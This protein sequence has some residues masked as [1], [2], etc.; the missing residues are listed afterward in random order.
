MKAILT[1]YHGPTKTKGSRVSATAE[2]GHRIIISWEPAWD[3]GRNH[4]TAAQVLRTK[5]GWSGK[6]IGGTLGN[7]DMCWVFAD[8][9][10][11][12]A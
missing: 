2:R 5:M 6:L 10:S 8:K 1:K 12:V 11:P 7:G 9:H 4:A 3:V